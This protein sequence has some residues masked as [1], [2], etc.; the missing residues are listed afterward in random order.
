MAGQ[1]APTECAHTHAELPIAPSLFGHD[2]LTY[3][4]LAALARLRSFLSRALSAALNFTPLR[5]FERVFAKVRLT[6]GAIL[7]SY[8]VL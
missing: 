1:P 5:T 6:N 8:T 2:Q 3:L 7:N 4:D